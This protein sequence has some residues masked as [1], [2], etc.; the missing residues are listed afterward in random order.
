MTVYSI[1]GDYHIKEE[2]TKE[3]DTAATEITNALKTKLHEKEKSA[4]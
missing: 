4:Q 1:H 2:A 3:L